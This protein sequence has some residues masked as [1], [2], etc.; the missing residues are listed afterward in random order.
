MASVPD[1][2]GRAG[3]KQATLH[4]LEKYAFETGSS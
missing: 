3:G 2:D 4:A 1:G